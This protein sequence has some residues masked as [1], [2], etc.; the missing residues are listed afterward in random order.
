MFDDYRELLGGAQGDVPN[1]AKL[2]PDP[3]AIGGV[4]GS[5]T[6][7]LAELLG[8]TTLAMASPV[9][10]A[11]DAYEW[12]PL[13][14]L[15]E[16]CNEVDRG[17]TMAAALHV[18]ERLLDERRERL[19]KSARVAWKVPGTFLW[20]HHLSSYFPAMQYI[21]LIRNGLDMA[22]SRN[23]RQARRHGEELGIDL[24]F[25]DGR[26]L[27]PASVLDYWLAGNERAI[28]DGQALLGNRF[29]LLRFEDL[30][31]EPVATLQQLEGFLDQPLL[32]ALPDSLLEQVSTPPTVGRYLEREWQTDFSSQQL[33]RVGRLGYRP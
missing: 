22:Y 13:G 1:T 7:V 8:A 19:N 25:R 17:R 14:P 28:R 21:H 9:N 33:E 10:R 18:F 12:P 32:E 31:A 6:R 24:E 5:G 11:L 4:G 23:Q 27:T 2:H 29:L 20:L 30:C 16:S 3:V 26:R 15:S